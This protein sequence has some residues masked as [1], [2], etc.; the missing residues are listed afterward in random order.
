M[1]TFIVT[2]KETV[3]YA[4]DVEA[5]DKIEAGDAAKEILA[6]SE[7]PYLDFECNCEAV[8][9]FRVETI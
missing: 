3:F 7:N 4:I 2:L 1:A 8:E 5:D 6:Q 9:I